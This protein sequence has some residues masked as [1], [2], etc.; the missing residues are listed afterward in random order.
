MYRKYK[1]IKTVVDGIT[2][3]SKAEAK[4]YTELKR[5]QLAE[6]ISDLRLQVRYDFE[7][8]GVKL[9]FYKADFVYI[10]DCKEVVEDK[11]GFKTP[12]YNLKKK[13]MKAFYGV[14]IYET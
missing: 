8:N 4:R 5:L 9:G 7:F 13:M 6:E 14:D 3:D 11:K 10:K 1:N 2:F 12:V